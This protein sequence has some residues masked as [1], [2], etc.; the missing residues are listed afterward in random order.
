MNIINYN[1]SPTA[2]TLGTQYRR[3]RLPQDTLLCV[4]ECREISMGFDFPVG[5][6]DDKFSTAKSIPLS[7]KVPFRCLPN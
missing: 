7:H 4:W 6:D 2:G 5:K 1:F 3:G